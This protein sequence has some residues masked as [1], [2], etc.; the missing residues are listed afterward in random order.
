MHLFIHIQGLLRSG[1]L[2]KCGNS[3]SIDA[4]A[5]GFRQQRTY[6]YPTHN[7]LGSVQHFSE[8][9]IKSIDSVQSKWLSVC[10]SAISICVNL[11]VVLTG[12]EGLHSCVLSFKVSI[13]LR[14]APLANAHFHFSP[15]FLCLGN[16]GQT[17]GKT[18]R[19]NFPLLK[20]YFLGEISG[21]VCIAH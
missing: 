7:T 6:D 15:Q 9:N 2:M 4:L 8:Q 14:T 21:T 10:L 11:Q 17:Y 1:N 3:C 16:S 13:W 20:V 12:M 5:A 18:R 19:F